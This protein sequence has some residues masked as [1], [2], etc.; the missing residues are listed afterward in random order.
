MIKAIAVHLQGPKGPLPM[1]WQKLNHLR[2]LIGNPGF[3]ATLRSKI[4]KDVLM[5]VPMVG[6]VHLQGDSLNDHGEVSETA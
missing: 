6:K 5:L 3:M 2:K 4:L 1:P